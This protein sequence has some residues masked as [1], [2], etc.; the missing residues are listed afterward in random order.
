MNVNSEFSSVADASHQTATG[1]SAPSC[2][3]VSMVSG[4]VEVT[5]RLRNADDLD[6]LLKVLEANKALFIKANPG[7]ID[8]LPVDRALAE[9]AADD[10]A[11]GVSAKVKCSAKKEPKSDQSN[12]KALANGAPLETEALTLT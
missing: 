7:D 1:T 2:Y 10:A 12:S 9:H 5:A 6:L 8:V 3:R 4:A 11:N